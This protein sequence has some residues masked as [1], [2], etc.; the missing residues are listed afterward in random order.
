MM[1]SAVEQ[2]MVWNSSWIMLW[3]ILRTRVFHIGIRILFQTHQVFVLTSSFKG[4]ETL[5]QILRKT[6]LRKLNF[7]VCLKFSRCKFKVCMRCC[8]SVAKFLQVFSLGY[9]AE[10]WPCPAQGKCTHQA[11]KVPELL[12]SLV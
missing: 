12:G 9:S 2:S 7:S 8:F 1:F 10:P 5:S 3:S 11:V 6:L 4:N